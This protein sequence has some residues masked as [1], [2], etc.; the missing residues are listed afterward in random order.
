M[1]KSASFAPF[2]RS[3]CVSARV[4]LNDYR[5]TS[6]ALL[7]LFVLQKRSGPYTSLGRTPI[8]VEVEEDAPLT[9]TAVLPNGKWIIPAPLTRSL[10]ASLHCRSARLGSAHSRPRPATHPLPH[11]I[12]LLLGNAT[13][14]Q[15]RWLT[16]FFENDNISPKHTRTADR[17]TDK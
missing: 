12:G 11:E 6:R 15:R 14:S 10:V 5:D 16:T 9:V 13:D 7:V 8:A 3:V 4:C 17:Q 1:V 2:L